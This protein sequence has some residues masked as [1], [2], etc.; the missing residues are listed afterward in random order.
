MAPNRTG[1]PDQVGIGAG[2]EGLN[3]GLM[4]L[5][6]AKAKR[7]CGREHIVEKDR[8]MREGLPGGRYVRKRA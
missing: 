7:R 5:C 6:V 2:G 8:R 3:A 1:S 4:S